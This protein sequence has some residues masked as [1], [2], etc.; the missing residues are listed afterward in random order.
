M[1]TC[2]VFKD[3]LARAWLR[4]G[5]GSM[6][7]MPDEATARRCAAAGAMEEACKAAM[8]ELL[9]G[10]PEDSPTSALRPRELILHKK[11]RAALSLALN[12]PGK[13]EGR[14]E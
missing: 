7:P 6:S 11:L 2:E 3:G 10:C 1:L 12:G 13:G 14:G 4:W 5:D 9:N 8:E